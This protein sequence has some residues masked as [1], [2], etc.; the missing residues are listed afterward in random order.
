MARS[1]KSRKGGDPD[2]FISLDYHVFEMR[3][4]KSRAEL[5]LIKRAT[6]LSASAH[7]RVMKAAKPGMLEYE[8]E[9]ELVAQYKSKGAEHAFLPIVGSGAN[10]CIL[11]YT[12]NSD[13]INDG[14]LVLVDSGAE[15]NYY[16]G[17]ITRTFPVNGTFSEAQK[18][19][20]NIVLDAQLAAIDATRPGNHWNVPHE[21]AVKVLT[22][23]LR[24][25]GVLKGKLSQLLKD[26]AYKP[27]YMHRTGHWL[28]MDVHDVGDYRIDGQWRELEPGMV[29][30][31]EPGLYLGN[32]RK[33]PKAYRNIGI[34]IEDDVV[35]TKKGCDVLS[36]DV[37]KT[38]SEIEAFMKG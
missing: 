33:I 12:E 36:G 6:K 17:D 1:S 38:V 10:G 14:E 8:L 26:E 37:P 18:T 21:A 3:L 19:L 2:G 24:E 27:Y 29:I 4:F 7:C 28:G 15:L 22:Q 31:V 23:G 34:R 11:H 13:R 16:A 5:A 35:V 20:Y 9:A 25:I 32:S 30:T